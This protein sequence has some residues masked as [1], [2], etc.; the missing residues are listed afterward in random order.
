MLAV[1]RTS[2][3]LLLAAMGAQKRGRR[4]TDPEEIRALAELHE[5]LRDVPTRTEV[6]VYVWRKGEPPEGPGLDDSLS[7]VKPMT[8]RKVRELLG[9]DSGYFPDH[10]GKR[11]F[12]SVQDWAD[13]DPDETFVRVVFFHRPAESHWAEWRREWKEHFKRFPPDLTEQ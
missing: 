3:A 9:G 13:E 12:V 6:Q 2:D 4:I 7:A 11:H 10:G 1:R 5:R 8:L